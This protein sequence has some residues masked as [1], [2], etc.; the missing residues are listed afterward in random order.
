MIELSVCLIVKNEED[1]LGRCLDCVKQFADEIIVVDTGSSDATKEIAKRYTENV[2]DF[3][4]VE[5]F[6]K[7]RNFSFSKA[8]KDYCMWID[9]DDVVLEKDI[10]KIIE[11][12]QTLREDVSIVMMKYN[13]GFDA[14][15]IP[16]FS[17]YRERFIKRS[18]NFQ[19]EGVI[20][21]IIPMRGNILHEDIAI[22]HRK[23]HVSD[24]DRNIRIFEQLLK[25]GKTLNPREQFY[26]AREL[27]YHA[28]Y[29]DAIQMFENFLDGKL[30]WIENNI[31]SCEMMGYCQYLIGREEEGLKSFYRSF[32]YDLPRAELCCDIGKH[33]YDRSMYTQ[34]IFW[35]EIAL[36]R[37]R[38]DT[39]GAFVRGDCYGYVPCLQLCVCHFK[40]GDLDR[41]IWY[42]EQAGAY[43]GD[44]KEVLSNRAFF[45]KE[46]ALR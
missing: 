39:S 10:E 16:T 30:G 9:A 44:S 42:N 19:W 36:A 8:T 6:S 46:K 15:G 31:D 27:Y 32:V 1:V 40:L 20:H 17:Y 5:D 2:F 33:Y 22:T 25:D 26:Y 29:E 23:E 35:Y 21:E 11:L 24:P 3:V 12:K 28:R 43:K 18:E 41:A 4:W 37:P 7:A 34:A 38:D 45:E 13:T 14:N